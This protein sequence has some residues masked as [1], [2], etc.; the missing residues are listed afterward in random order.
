MMEWRQLLECKFFAEPKQYIYKQ[1]ILIGGVLAVAGALFF[2]DTSA[3]QVQELQTAIQS[4]LQANKVMRQEIGELR[5]QIYNISHNDRYLEQLA[6]NKLALS[7]QDEE[8]YIFQDHLKKDANNY[9][10]K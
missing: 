1:W 8:V 7:R 9:I 10:D 3:S 4:Q 6:R 5:S 2:F